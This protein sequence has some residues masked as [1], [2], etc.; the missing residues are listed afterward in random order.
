MKLK[1][2]SRM[3][4]AEVKFMRRAAKHIEKDYKGTIPF[5]IN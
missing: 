3:T 4:A 1:D 2:K 5:E